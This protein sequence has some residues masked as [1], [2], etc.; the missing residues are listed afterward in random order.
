[1]PKSSST[2]L[3]CKTGRRYHLFIFFF[4]LIRTPK[5]YWLGSIYWEPRD[6]RVPVGCLTLSERVKQLPCDRQ[7]NS[8]ASYFSWLDPLVPVGLSRG[9][10][11]GARVSVSK[12]M[13]NREFSFQSHC[14]SDH[15]SSCGLEK[16]LWFAGV[17]SVWVAAY[18]QY[19]G[20]AVGPL[21][22]SLQMVGPEFTAGSRSSL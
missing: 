11:L 15:L 17:H 10:R 18:V 20:K 6:Q 19:A 4:S 3:H 1:M 13:K 5:D 12:R 14:R 21:N 9:E 22:S 16:C 8:E 2:A 7:F